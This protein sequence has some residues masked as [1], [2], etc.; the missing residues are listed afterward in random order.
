MIDSHLDWQQIIFHQS[1]DV[2]WFSTYFRTMYN[3]LIRKA[4]MHVTPE[5]DKNDRK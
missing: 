2:N 3:N 1:W 5:I 4:M